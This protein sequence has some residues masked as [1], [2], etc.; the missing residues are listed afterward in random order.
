MWDKKITLAD[1]GIKD[2]KVEL[3][4][5]EIEL[6]TILHHLKSV[7]YDLKKSL[8]NIDLGNIDEIE[9]EFF[10]RALRNKFGDIINEKTK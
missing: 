5:N 7:G 8:L 4:L 3:L 6:N 2:L 1:F 9:I 10:K